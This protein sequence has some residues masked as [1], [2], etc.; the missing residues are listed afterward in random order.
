MNSDN[1]NSHTLGKAH[2][3]VW[4]S[5]SQAYWGRILNVRRATDANVKVRV[6]GPSWTQNARIVHKKLFTEVGLED[7][8]K[9]L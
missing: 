6:W 9:L 1:L 2:E 4:N 3:V 7:A 5:H 8:W